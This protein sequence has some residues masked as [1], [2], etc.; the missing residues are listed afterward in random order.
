[1]N[2]RPY[3]QEAI[4]SAYNHLRTRDDNPCIVIPTAGGKTPILATICRDA[5]TRWNGRVLVLAHVKELLEQAVEK[6]HIIAPDMWD[7]IGLYSAGLGSRDV[8]HPIIVAGIQSIY[9]RAGELGRFDLILIDEAHLIPPDGEGRYRQFLTDAQVVNP[10]VRLIGLTATPYR[11]STGTIC[12]TDNLLNSICYEVGVKEL[13]TE[14]Y[15][16]PLK[17]RSGIT[18]PNTDGLHI[19]AGEF[20]A[21]EVSELMND[22]TLVLNACHEIMGLTKPCKSVLV[23]ASGVEH[24]Q[25]I[26]KVIEQKGGSCGMV[27]GDTLDF[28]R[29]DTLERF[30]AGTLKFLV[31]VNVLTTGF[32]APNIDCVVLLRPTASPGLYYQMVGRGFRIHPN[33]DFCLVLDYGNNVIRHGPV[34]CLTLKAASNG[35]G[36]APAKECPECRS[37]I[38]AGFSICPECG[39][40]FP[41]PERQAHGDQAGQEGILSGEVTD[42]EHNIQSVYYA[43]HSKRGAD[44]DAPKTMRVDYRITLHDHQSE[45]VCFEHRGYARNKAEAWW[46]ARSKAPVPDTVIEAVEIAMRGELAEPTSI[47]VR[48]VSGDK[49]DRI[50]KHEL[51]EA[52]IR[53]EAFEPEEVDT[54]EWLTE[55]NEAD[56]PF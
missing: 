48:S 45:W 24:A 36:D 30:K 14:G 47:T 20:I 25:R 40:V 42:T 22:N 28:D 51:G 34:D 17:S 5:V 56:I 13:I 9:K 38:H 55:C 43:V 11:M 16:C 33:K 31:N 12:D 52:G 6:L 54:P 35:S 4:D 2:L 26:Q 27:T 1:M 23:F 19:R 7:K 50:I 41:E 21:S 53:P 10:K 3:Q 15:L 39:F 8:E 44:E 29:T 37:L 46:K 49:F 18:K 32:D